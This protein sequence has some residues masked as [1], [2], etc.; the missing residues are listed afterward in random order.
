M[1][2]TTSWVKYFSS[3]SW[4][5]LD[6]GLPRL[7]AMLDRECR[8]D[9]PLPLLRLLPALGAGVE[10]TLGGGT[11][12]CNYAHNNRNLKCN[13]N[14]SDKNTEKNLF[15]YLNRHETFVEKLTCVDRGSGG[16]SAGGAES[17]RTG[18]SSAGADGAVEL[19]SHDWEREVSSHGS[20]G[21][22]LNHCPAFSACSL[23]LSS[24]WL[25]SS[26]CP[27]PD[28][29]IGAPAASCWS[30]AAWKAGCVR[31]WT[32]ELR[33]ES[34][35]PDLLLRRLR[36]FFAVRRCSSTSGLILRGRPRPRGLLM[37]EASPGRRSTSDGENLDAGGE[38]GSDVW[39]VLWIGERRGSAL[40]S[41]FT[42]DLTSFFT[43]ETGSSLTRTSPEAAYKELNCMLME[44]IKRGILK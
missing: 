20:L 26:P 37:R 41:A 40:T 5:R 6:G 24:G 36:R 22:R 4:K 25:L 2:F 39:G 34:S 44:K 12:G 1:G 42:G 43:G 7:F 13:R 10:Q 16:I 28:A 35:P 15:I 23:I 38:Q 21:N 8:R 31:S 29:V 18:A 9:G 19:F 17:R 32:G 30:T 27:A 11:A 14:V 3:T 33:L